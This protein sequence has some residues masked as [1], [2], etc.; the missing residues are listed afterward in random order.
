VPAEKRFLTPTDFVHGIMKFNTNV[1]KA[2]AEALATALQRDKRVDYFDF[3]QKL[4]DAI[5]SAEPAATGVDATLRK[6]CAVLHPAEC[7]MLQD[8]MTRIRNIAVQADTRDVRVMIDAEQTFYQLAI[9]H[10]TRELQHE[11]NKTTPRI[12]NTYQCY[13]TTTEARLHHDL[14]R[15]QR[16]GWC[17]GGKVVRGAYMVQEREVAALLG[18][19]SPIHPDKA[20]TD[21]CYD[22]CA[23][24]ILDQMAVAGGTPL[25]VLFGSH[26]EESIQ[27]I[28]DLTKALPPNKCS[29]SVAQLLGMGNHISYPLAAEGFNVFKYVPYGPVKETTAY[30]LRRAIENSTMLANPT[31]ELTLMQDELR[32]RFA[33]SFII[34][35]AVAFWVVCLTRVCVNVQK[36]RSG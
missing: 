33:I 27:R 6:L 25:G 2:E 9:D 21:A 23:K 4:A 16:D 1:T 26:N 3:T 15:A 8:S 5:F 17:W 22:R 30:L 28:V 13:T 19:P 36:H 20:T 10:V 14:L 11:F 35:S 12:Y 24:R 29:V 32:R 34:A 7:K 31:S 18:Y